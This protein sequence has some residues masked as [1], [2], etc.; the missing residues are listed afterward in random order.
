[1]EICLD[2]KDKVVKFYH[3]K[4]RARDVQNQNPRKNCS[5]QKEAPSAKQSKVVHNIVK[6]VEEYSQSC[7]ISSIRVVK[8]SKKLIIESAT[9]VKTDEAASQLSSPPSFSAPS[10]SCDVAIK[11]EPVD[12]FEDELFR[13]ETVD[14]STEALDFSDIVV[15]EEPREQP[16]VY[17]IHQKI[18]HPRKNSAESRHRYNHPTQLTDDEGTLVSKAALKMRAYRERLRKPEN[19]IRYLLHLEHQREWNRKHYIKKQIITGQP[20]RSRRR[21]AKRP[22][23]DFVER[24]D[25]ELFY[26]LQ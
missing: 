15:K 19:K 24:S 18:S 23:I 8:H 6:I 10:A 5:T 17:N 1:M 26:N 25:A 3:F 14:S 4:R 11:E 13:I 16:I 22:N 21:R 7:S 20:I 9:E 12:S 2:C